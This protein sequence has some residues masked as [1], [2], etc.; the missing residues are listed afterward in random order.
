M[1]NI[2]NV[3]TKAITVYKWKFHTHTRI[4]HWI[5][6]YGLR[7]STLCFSY[8]FRSLTSFLY[9]SF[10]V[11]PVSRHV[12]WYV[13]LSTFSYIFTFV[14]VSL[15]TSHYFGYIDMVFSLGFASNKINMIVSL[16]LFFFNFEN[17]NGDEVCKCYIWSWMCLSAYF[18]IWIL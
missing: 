10:C 18:V 9:R 5:W 11:S 12:W 13:Y 15:F 8:I 6:L 17:C 1:E 14:G 2:C 4:G 7:Y 16:F 3:H